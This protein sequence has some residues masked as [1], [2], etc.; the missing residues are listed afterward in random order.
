MSKPVLLPRSAPSTALLTR[1]AFTAAGLA[2][3]LL[4]TSGR[5]A[6][7][8]DVVEAISGF[9]NDLF[10]SRLTD[11]HLNAVLSPLS[12]GLCIAM[13]ASGSV[14]KTAAEFEAALRLRRGACAQLP[15][16]SY[17]L[18]KRLK[19]VAGL[20]LANALAFE[21]TPAGFRP[22]YVARIRDR[23]DGEVLTQA[24]VSDVN[25]WVGKKTHGMIPH[26]IERMS[27]SILLNA[28]HF[29][30]AWLSP[31]DLEAKGVFVT[32][33]AESIMVPRMKKA[34]ARGPALSNAQTF[35]LPYKDSTVT[36]IVVLPAPGQPVARVARDLP[37]DTFGRILDSTETS[38]SFDYL[39]MP[40]FRIDAGMDMKTTLMEAG[41]RTMFDP[42]AADFAGIKAVQTPNLYFEQVV[43]RCVIKVDRLGT[44]AA[45]TTAMVFRFTGGATFGDERL[46]EVNR[47][48]LFYLVD[49]STRAILMQGCINDPR[50]AAA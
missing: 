2:A 50:S 9:G 26:L 46:I 36:M 20:S 16:A 49:R 1:R 15:E 12:L 17:A 40:P 29:R 28:L 22:D 7:S 18:S 47:P 11:P 3:G 45:A 39:L 41:L 38:Q 4:P 37:P 14:G 8:I 25:A 5:A 19:T 33:G 43:H 13:A 6:S 31:A 34:A 48:F 27:A 42:V 23:F 24:T 32:G 21:G 35:A 30:G 10:L 44:E